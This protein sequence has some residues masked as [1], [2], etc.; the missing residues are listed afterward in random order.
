MEKTFRDILAEFL[1]GNEQEFTSM[2]LENRGMGSAS[3]YVFEPLWRPDF[4]QNPSRE[5]L[6]R[7]RKTRVTEP[8]PVTPQPKKTPPPPPPEEVLPLEKLPPAQ[9]ARVKELIELGA[10]DL[11]QGLTVKRLKKAHRHLARK[12]HPDRLT[13]ATEE[14]L[15]TAAAKFLRVQA[16]YAALAA[17]LNSK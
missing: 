1:E 17:F 2:P 4:T 3:A 15:K 6:N 16:A 12:F 14:Q 11:T 9:F 5:G 10:C 13:G 7:Y 8:G